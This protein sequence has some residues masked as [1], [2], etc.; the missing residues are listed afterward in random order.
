MTGYKGFNSDLTCK[1]FKY[2]IGKTYKIKEEP[3]ICKR[4]FHFCYNLKNVIDNYPLY[5]KHTFCEIEALG[6]VDSDEFY[7][8]CCTNKIKILRKLDLDEILDII[9]MKDKEA[10][11]KYYNDDRFNKHQM[12]LIYCGFQEGLD[13]STYAKPEF[14]ER[15]MHV[16]FRGLIDGLDI[17]IY[18][19]PEFNEDQMYLI[20]YGLRE[21]L[22]VSS[23]AKPELNY[24]QMHVM[25]YEL[26]RREKNNGHSI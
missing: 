8:K 17:S 11:I 20:Y 23:Y 7:K 6:K 25:L 2:E 3:I 9:G 24:D 14:N 4:G 5:K 19:H 18:A 10:F 13:I 21:G 12:Y 16:M 26:S 1:G 15:Q 22:D